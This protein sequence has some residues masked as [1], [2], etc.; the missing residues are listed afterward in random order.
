MVYSPE[1]IPPPTPEE[2]PN[3]TTPEGR[4]EEIE[5]IIRGL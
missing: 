3:L 5:R 4:Q 2:K 1:K